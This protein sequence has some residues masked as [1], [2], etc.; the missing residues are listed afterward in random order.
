MYLEK[1]FSALL[2][3]ATVGLVGLAPYVIGWKGSLNLLAQPR[4]RLRVSKPTDLA[5]QVYGVLCVGQDL[6]EKVKWAP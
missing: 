5:L 1:P 3:G 4:Q 2:G 6:T